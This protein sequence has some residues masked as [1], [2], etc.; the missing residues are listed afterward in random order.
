MGE[1]GK[2]EKEKI[3]ITRIRH[4]VARLIGIKRRVDHRQKT[5][6]E[7]PRAVEQA[8]VFG[9][10]EVLIRTDCGVGAIGRT[11]Q[12]GLVFATRARAR[13]GDGDELVPV[14]RGVDDGAVGELLLR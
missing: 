14:Q 2:G 13:R 9:R 1:F 11:L 4:L 6:V 3:P 8:Q 10:G 12:P 7:I 5:L